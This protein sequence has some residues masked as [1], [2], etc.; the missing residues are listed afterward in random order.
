MRTDLSAIAGAVSGG[1]IGAGAVLGALDAVFGV[2]VSVFAG[3]AG[4]ILLGVVRLEQGDRFASWLSIFAHYLGGV[5]LTSLCLA[6]SKLAR[7][8]PAGGVAFV[9]G[10][11]LLFAL[12]GVVRIIQRGPDALWSKFTNKTTE[13]PAGPPPG[14]QQSGGSR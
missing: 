3:C 6:Y 1:T 8:L 2:P 5:F 9:I 4:G 14:D 11:A 7:E 12:P 13:P 10:F